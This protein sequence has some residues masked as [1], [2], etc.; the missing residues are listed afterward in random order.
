M[1]RARRHVMPPVQ[2]RQQRKAETTRSVI[3]SKEH[4]PRAAGCSGGC[5]KGKRAMEAFLISLLS[6]V[7]TGL[8]TA[9]FLS[10]MPQPQAV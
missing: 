10:W 8:I 6:G 3:P 2:L 5:V 1:K 7:L 9:W 4:G